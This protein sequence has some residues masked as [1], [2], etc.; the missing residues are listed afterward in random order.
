V[1]REK[2]Q[3]RC[4]KK[5]R[6]PADPGEGLMNHRVEKKPGGTTL[7]PGLGDGGG[8]GAPGK[9]SLTEQLGTQPA[10]YTVRSG[11]T[12]AVLAAKLQTTAW[13]LKAANPDKLR[14]YPGKHGVVQG[15]DAGAVIHVPAPGASGA[16]AASADHGSAGGAGHGS[17]DH[18]GAGHGSADH[19][20]ADHGSADHGSADHGSAGHGSAKHGNA[21]H[22][23]AEHGGAEADDGTAA[24][25]STTSTASTPA[26]AA[27]SAAGSANSATG[28][29]NSAAGSANSAAGS[30]NSATGAANGAAHGASPSPSAHG[31]ASATG[32]ASSS[33]HGSPETGAP[34][35]LAELDGK[36]RGERLSTFHK[37]ELGAIDKFGMSKTGRDAAKQR[38][39]WLTAQA[40][41][42]AGHGKAG[43]AFT[44]AADDLI[45]HTAFTEDQD[46][47]L[48]A[49]KEFAA[50]PKP[51]GPAQEQRAAIDWSKAKLELD[52]VA[53]NP[54]LKGRLTRYVRFLAW[55]GL[56]KGPTTAGSVMRSP[57]SAHKLSVAW[58]FNL[59]ANTSKGSSLHKPD[60]RK[61]LVANVTAAGGTD[62]DGNRWLGPATVE[63]LKARKDN[64]A[65]LFA[66]I[67]STAAPE[68]NQVATQSAI[69]AEGYKSADKRHPNVL[70]GASVSNHLLGEAVDL[71]P[72]FVLPNK[73]DPLI[74]AIAL[75][76]GLWRAVKDNAAS[77]EHWH[78]ERLGMPPGAEADDH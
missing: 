24:T 41:K 76:F 57:Q 77:P 40:I 9:R 14:S 39:A 8:A 7:V 35:P 51:L 42:T 55:A 45:D 2:C 20:S 23:G 22:R 4:R 54:D 75:Y 46:C 21:D 53:L 58:M 13:A 73:F 70:G 10:T 32:A 34:A 19:G 26:G 49:A 11:E 78:Y 66:Y 31:A 69:A 48:A 3:F 60:N 52:G 64:D 27:N 43:A 25:I 37:D 62:A 47:V 29:A 33:A 1:A 28:S 30:A 16:P 12:L 71:F 5:S 61:Q 56:L 18:G 36:A 59:A 6:S 50:A 68:A 65:A 17:A 63:G 74:D 44:H 67:K 38:G 72:D 15:F